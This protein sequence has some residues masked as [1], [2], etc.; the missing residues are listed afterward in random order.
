MTY[1]SAIVY[2]KSGRLDTRDEGRHGWPRSSFRL[3]DFD[4]DHNDH[5]DD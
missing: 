3:P 4:D 2:N 5:N 1:A